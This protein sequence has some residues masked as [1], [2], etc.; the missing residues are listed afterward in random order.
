MPFSSGVFSLVAG[1]PVV[2]GTTISSTTQNDTMNDIAD[3]GL[4]LCLIKDGTQTPTANLPM[5][6]FKLTGLGA[7]TA[8]ADAPRT[9][10]VQNQAFS[11]L[12]SVAGTNTITASVTPT[13]AAYA[14]GQ[15]FRMLPLNT[16]T[17]QATLNVSS[18]GAVPIFFDAKTTATSSAII[19]G[20][21]IE[22]MYISTTSSTGMHIIGS[23]GFNPIVRS[24]LW[25]PAV[26]GTATYTTQVGTYTKIA[27]T[28]H[29]WMDLQINSIG[30][31]SATTVS[32]LPFTA[33]ATVGA[34]IPVSLF[35]SIASNVVYICGLIAASG[36]TMTF[37]T[38]TVAGGTS[39]NANN[40]FQNSA[41]IICSGSYQV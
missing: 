40:I 16:N 38:I 30:N 28:V 8:V 41:R 12:T 24:G 27:D 11:T 25:T 2:T 15:V 22:F 17:A 5:G 34:A 10:Q 31:G 32:G 29:I 20:V 3:N 9:S 21:P 39:S 23:G 33:T 4:S 37:S 7:A 6:G 35:A 18:L 13:P 26:G 14:E 36:T 19:A 1:N